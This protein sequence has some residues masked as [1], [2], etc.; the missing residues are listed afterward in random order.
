MQAL[1]E[2]SEESPQTPG[3]GLFAGRVRKFAAAKKIP[4]IGW[5]NVSQTKAHPLL[6]GL[7]NG[8]RF[9]FIHSF[10]CPLSEDAIL[11]ADY[12]ESF[13]AAAAKGNVVATQFHPEKSAQTGALLLQNFVEGV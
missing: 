12:G 4:H 8:A 6:R 10:F 1:F 2:G 3:L 13:A 11:S 9:Y 7:Q 5:N